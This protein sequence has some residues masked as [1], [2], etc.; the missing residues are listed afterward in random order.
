MSDASKSGS[1]T[2]AS[3]AGASPATAKAERPD[4]VPYS[5]LFLFATP[6]DKAMLAVGVIAA[7]LNG[8]IFPCF[9]LVF[10]KLLNS[11]GAS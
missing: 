8:V 6:A 7:A 11:L 2:P 10:G 5:R 1:A 3:A 9:T 4:V